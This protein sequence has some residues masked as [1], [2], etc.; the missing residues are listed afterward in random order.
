MSKEGSGALGDEKHCVVCG[1]WFGWR[2]RWADEWHRIVHCGSRCSRRRLTTTDT[3]LE[4]EILRMLE[5]GF[6]D[7][8]HIVVDTAADGLVFTRGEPVAA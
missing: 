7:G 8:D 2:R 5:G 1:R 4:Q 3:A 6:A